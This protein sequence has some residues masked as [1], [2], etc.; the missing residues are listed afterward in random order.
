[1]PHKVVVTSPLAW[2]MPPSLR[3]I[4]Q[5]HPLACEMVREV[6]QVCCNGLVS[7][8]RRQPNKAAPLPVA[9]DPQAARRQTSKQAGWQQADM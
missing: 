2:K 9:A 1:M 5:K 7:S 6:T 3:N 8:T 4:L